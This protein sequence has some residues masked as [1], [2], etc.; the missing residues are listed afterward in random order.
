M[1]K[2]FLLWVMAA[3]T[4]TLGLTSCGDDDDNAQEVP[5]VPTPDEP[6]PEDPTPDAPELVAVEKSDGVFVVNTGNMSGGIEGSLT[7]YD[8]DTQTVAQGVYAKANNVGLGMTVNHA[9]V[10]GSKIY[11]VGSGE[12]TI[13]V[14]DRKTLKKVANIAVKKDNGEVAQPRQAVAGHG[15]V[16]VST[17]NNVVI[18]IDTLTNTIDKTYQCGYYTEGMALQGKYLYTADSNYGY[19]KQESAFPSISMIN[20]E[21]EETTTIT[22]DLINNPVDVKIAGERLFILDSGHYDESW[23]QIGAGVYELSNGEVKL[24]ADATEMAVSKD[25]IFLFNAPYSYPAT[26]PTYKVF[27]TTSNILADLCDGADIESPSKISVD[28]I[29]G[30]VYITSYH[31]GVYGYA[32]YKGNG[33]CTVYDENGNKQSQFDCGVGAGYVIPNT[34]IEYVKQ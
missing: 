1:K 25:K 20:L 30:Y 28:P 22:H 33:Y 24:I 8:Y 29:K 17:F 2:Y 3:M 27:D 5:E 4:A 23:N 13:F 9:V 14:A 32:D 6:T 11:I 16:Y 10:Y 18:A 31:M 26:T 19:G 21:T 12:S 7:Y 34:Y 15:H